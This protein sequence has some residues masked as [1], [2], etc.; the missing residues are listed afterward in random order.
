MNHYSL[1]HKEPNNG[2]TKR[3]KNFKFFVVLKSVF[4]TWKAQSWP[5]KNSI[6]SL[7]GRSPSFSGLGAAGDKRDFY[8]D[9]IKMK[10]KKEA[11]REKKDL[12]SSLI[13]EKR[14]LGKEAGN[15]TWWKIPL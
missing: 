12:C 6:F 11:K 8:S 4:W 14:D 3:L 9:W 13:Q 2:D 7:S 15:K 5:P 1:I 10:K